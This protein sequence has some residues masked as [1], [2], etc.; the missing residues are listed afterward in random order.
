MP[1]SSC[2]AHHF[3]C[4]IPCLAHRKTQFQLS[5]WNLDSIYF[6]T[7]GLRYPGVQSLSSILGFYKLAFPWCIPDSEWELPASLP[8][9]PLFQD[10]CAKTWLSSSSLRLGWRHTASADLS[11]SHGARPASGSA[12]NALSPSVLGQ[13]SHLLWVGNKPLSALHHVL[14]VPQQKCFRPKE[15][16]LSRREPQAH[17]ASLSLNASR[18]ALSLSLPS[19]DKFSEFLLPF[20]I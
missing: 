2:L 17:V 15:F 3:L 13:L 4:L 12:Y 16:Q 6:E 7:E 8:S 14:E 5:E 10:S 1:C 20:L 11:L 19:S 9:P 18:L